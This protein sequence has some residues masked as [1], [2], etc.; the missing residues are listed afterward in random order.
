[1]DGGNSET[2]RLRI[3]TVITEAI[4]LYR[5]NYKLF[6]KI[7]L[8]GFLISSLFNLVTSLR[9]VSENINFLIFYNMLVYL[10]IVPAFYYDVKFSVALYAAIVERYQNRE[11]NLKASLLNASTKFWRYVAVNVQ[12]LLLLAGPAAGMAISFFAVE[13]VFLKSLLLGAFGL[14][15]VYFLTVYGFAPF[16]AIVEKDRKKYFTMS[17]EL[18]RGDF[19]K[20]LVLLVLI[21]ALFKAPLYL[22]LYLFN[23]YSKILPL[24]KIA[25]TVL[26]QLFQVVLSP[27]TCLLLVISYFNLL[28]GKRLILGENK[29]PSLVRRLRDHDILSGK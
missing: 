19:F 23:D 12:L 28:T 1:M 22:Y 8:I 3:S 14:L 6:L 15:M 9:Y 16:L 29:K 2:S 24:Y 5:S 26:S 7:T 25:A 17:K 18:V 4:G 21:T 20:I 10:T 27:F 11:T 13:N